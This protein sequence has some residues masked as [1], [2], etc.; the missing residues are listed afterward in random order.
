MNGDTIIA[1]FDTPAHAELA[2]QDLLAAGL[3]DALI[4][5]HEAALDAARLESPPTPPSFWQRLFG[6]APS[7]EPVHG[8]ADV[9]ERGVA[10]GGSVIAVRPALERID[11]VISIL[12]SHQPIDMDERHSDPGPDAS[13]SGRVRRYT[14]ELPVDDR[15]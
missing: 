5:R 1:L 13:A 15:A 14:L 8:D 12:E 4:E 3:P 2:V 11:E 6:T 10:A 7:G 9:F